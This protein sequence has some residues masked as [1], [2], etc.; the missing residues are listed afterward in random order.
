MIVLRSN[1]RWRLKLERFQ[2]TFMSFCR[3]QLIYQDNLK[4]LLSK[5]RHLPKLACQASK[6]KRTILDTRSESQRGEENIHGLERQSPR[7]RKK[8]VLVEQTFVFAGRTDILSLRSKDPR[9]S[10]FRMYKWCMQTT[11]KPV[12]MRVAPLP[13]PNQ[14]TGRASRSPPSRRIP[15]PECQRHFLLSR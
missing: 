4:I 5:T 6:L 14:V 3:A 15:C 7:Q 9:I 13:L 8:L 2:G 1:G 10:I 12:I 11:L